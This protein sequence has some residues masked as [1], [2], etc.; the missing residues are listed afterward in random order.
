MTV[1]KLLSLLLAVLMLCCVTAVSS[2]A[3]EQPLN[4]VLLGD[5]IA[6]GAG[7]YNSE[8]ACYGKIVADTNGYNYANYAVNGHR[9]ADLIE[10][11]SLPEVAEQVKNADIISMSIGG[12]DYLQQNLPKIF[13]Q[14]AVGNYKIVDDVEEIFRENFDTI[15]TTIRELNPDVTIL[16]QTLYNPRVD[17]LRDFYDLAV[18]RINRS[19]NVYL[20]EHPGAFEIVDVASVLT[21]DHPEYIAL[22]SIHPSSLGNEEIAKLVLA[23]LNELGLGEATEPV[24]RTVGIDQIPYAVRIFKL[25]KDFFLKIFGVFTVTV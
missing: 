17:L 7:V 22:D 24:V 2:C 1:R 6:W 14:V 9:T 12:N 15:I 13:A 5:S 3:Q 18:V 21:K 25:I 8:A 20:E 4:Y 19:I 23:K 11:L 16:A 10:R